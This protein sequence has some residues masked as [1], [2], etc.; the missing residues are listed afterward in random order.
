MGDIVGL[1]DVC[2]ALPS[3]LPDRPFVT[4]GRVAEVRR[5]RGSCYFTLADGAA[6]LPCALLRQNAARTEF[7][8]AV[9]QTVEV[10]GYA[11]CFRGRWQLYVV[12]ARLVQGG[13]GWP[14]GYRSRSARRVV[15]GFYRLLDGLFGPARG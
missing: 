5:V 12:E 4:R 11:E 13:R 3:A 6:R 7:W 10:T 14:V 1:R 8:V 9:G 2:A 15:D